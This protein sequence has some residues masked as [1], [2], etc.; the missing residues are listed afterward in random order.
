MANGHSKLSPSASERWMNCPGS[1]QLSEGLKDEPGPWAAEGTAAHTVAELLVTGQKTLEQIKEMVGTVLRTWDGFDVTVTNEMVAGAVL[2]RDVIETDIAAL[3]AEGRPAPIAARAEEKIGATSVDSELWGTSDFIL[4]QKGNKLKVYDYKFGKGK[5]VDPK[6]NSQMSVYGLGAVDTLAGEAFDEVE[7]VIVQPRAAHVDGAVRRW[8]TNMAW[9]REFRE[10]LRAAVAK[11]READ[12]YANLKAGKWCFFCLAKARCPEIKKEVTRQAQI[13]FSVVP[14]PAKPLTKDE[15][16]STAGLLD[17]GTVP[18]EKLGAVLSWEDAVCAW[19]DA[20]RV[21]ARGL[22]ERGVHVPGYKLVEGRSNRQW[23]RTPAEVID[24]LSLLVDEDQLLTPRELKSPAQVEQ[25]IGKG[26]LEKLDLVV[27]PKGGLSVATMDDP[28]PE[29]ASPALIEAV[30]SD[31]RAVPHGDLLD[32]VMLGFETAPQ[33]AAISA[34]DLLEDLMPKKSKPA[35]SADPLAELMGTTPPAN[36][37]VELLETPQAPA[38]ADPL[39][40]LMGDMP[41]AEKPK[42]EKKYK[43]IWPE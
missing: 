33:S 1:V 11:T 37:L 23:K 25:V 15:R 21:Q 35:A 22:L 38:P 18:P 17:P 2:Y 3:R 42:A 36:S 7:L 19:F 43:R 12:P 4:Y 16:Q 26:K 5:V 34:V 40:E 20:L 10:K 13:D 39:A 24:A 28:R 31:P 8:K 14:A 29:V 32:S 6:R 30:D 41:A 9:L 27:K